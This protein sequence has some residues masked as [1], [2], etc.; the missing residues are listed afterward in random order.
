MATPTDDDA[1]AYAAVKFPGKA[2]QMNVV[3]QVIRE[4]HVIPDDQ[5]EKEVSW[6]YKYV[7][8]APAR[9]QGLPGRSRASNPAQL[10]RLVSRHLPAIS[11]LTSST[12]ASRRSR[13]SP[14]TS[15]PSTA[16]R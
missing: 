2:D 11:A 13:L 7:G 5:V 3:C 4:K 15:S 16:P 12:S 9:C 10:R 6:F 1:Q 8:R 14:S